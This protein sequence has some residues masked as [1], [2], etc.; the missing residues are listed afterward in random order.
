M[1][2]EQLETLVKQAS[3]AY[4]SGQPIM[5]D[6]KFDQYVM[7]L[8]ATKP[9]SEVLRKTGFGYSPNG[10]KGNKIP[11]VHGGMESI[12]DKPR[13]LEDVPTNIRKNVR[14]SA[15]LDGLSGVV[16]IENGKFV[17][18]L[19][20]GDGKV[21]IDKTSKFSAMLKTLGPLNI[22]ENITC[23]VRGEFVISNENWNKM[24]ASGTKKKNSRNAASGIINSDDVSLE[25]S[26]LEFIPYK[27]I[28][29]KDAYSNLVKDELEL[30][31]EWFPNFPK[32]PY[33]DVDSYDESFLLN[34]YLKWKEVWPCDG[35][36]IT[37]NNVEVNN[38]CISYKEA[39]YKFDTLKK[40][41]KVTS[42]DWQMSR[43]NLFK[44]VANLEPIEL[45]G[46]TIKRVTLHNAATVKTNNIKPGTELMILKS[47][48]V[49]PYLE[50]VITTDEST[51]ASIISVCPKCG[52]SLVWDGVDIKCNNPD[53]NN[54]SY[55]ALMIW[56]K[57]I[58]IVDGFSDIL[59]NKYFERFNIYTLEDVYGIDLEYVKNTLVGEG[60]QSVKFYNVLENLQK[61]I[62]PLSKALLALNIQR[63]G[64]VSSD[65]LSKDK[66]FI[67]FVK[68]FAD[69]GFSHDWLQSSVDKLNYVVSQVVGEAT[70]KSICNNLESFENLKYLS[71]RISAK[72]EKKADVSGYV[73]I[74][75][76]LNTCSRKEFEDKIAK[77]GWIA[78]D[79]ISKKV[80]Y[81]ITNTPNSS[82]SK[83]K[84]ADE[85][86]IKK[87]TELEFLE[88]LEK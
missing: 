66:E 61:S 40:S 16:H 17:R 48:D 1:T 19:T 20:R 78:K 86:G 18:C 38:D 5:S 81:L 30:I 27:I 7:W 15:K 60:V 67:L 49:I 29:M 51:E 57:H 11:H 39:A 37:S 21:G 28:Y 4:Y 12:L 52:S 68:E 71:G 24:L 82:T 80:S 59:L 41:T 45:G 32:L 77:Y 42:I 36:V 8:K 54:V 3:E 72:A 69:S 35:V 58:G 79:E 44:P 34:N 55:S 22:P 23:E 26:Y 65:K 46:S 62:V 43:L 75:G 84:K 63:L 74:T 73:C 83:N 87:L 31:Q 33:I 2:A 76:K 6:S 47:G 9:D 50:D 85:L 25:I 10:V 70:A 64:D 13:T 56:T 53:C 88:L 14:V